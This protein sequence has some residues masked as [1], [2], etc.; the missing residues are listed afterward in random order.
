MPEFQDTI[1]IGFRDWITENLR[2][3]ESAVKN[4]IRG[5]VYVN[6]IEETDGGIN[7]AIVVR[8]IHPS[9]DESP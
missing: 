3:P 1:Y 8:G 5:T 9:L 7:T 4:G 6:F 2:Y